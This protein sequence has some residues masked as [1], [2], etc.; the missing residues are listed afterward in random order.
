MRL[1]VPNLIDAFAPWAE[2]RRG[3]L[4]SGFARC[5]AMFRSSA[6]DA[7]LFKVVFGKGYVSREIFPM[8]RAHLT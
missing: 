6:S 3:I 7:R 8:C 2:H 5:A 4:R 1:F